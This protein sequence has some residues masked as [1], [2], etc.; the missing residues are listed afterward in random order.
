MD[1]RARTA[2]LVAFFLALLHFHSV[3]QTTDALY[4]DPAKPIN[5]RVDDLIGRMTPEEKASQLVN[6]APALPRLQVPAYHWWGEALPGVAKSGTW[7]LL[8]DP[9]GLASPFYP[10][11]I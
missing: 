9:L 6:Q 3:A 4:L 8:P 2:V 1:M 11:L 5:A 7:T 10:S